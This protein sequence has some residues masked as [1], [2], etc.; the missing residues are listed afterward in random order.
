MLFETLCSSETYT[1]KEL[2]LAYNQYDQEITQAITNRGCVSDRVLLGKKI[3]EG[4]L[5]DLECNEAEK[6]SCFEHGFWIGT[7]LSALLLISCTG[8]SI[9]IVKWFW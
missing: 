7:I 6:R 9:L 1:K 2:E 3:S 8:I 5:Y 4:I